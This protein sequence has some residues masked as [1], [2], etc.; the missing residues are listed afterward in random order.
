MNS[1]PKSRRPIDP[2]GVTL[3]ERQPEEAIERQTR[4]EALPHERPEGQDCG[5]GAWHRGR[6]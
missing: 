1:R 6:R 5:R 4:D 2:F 3:R